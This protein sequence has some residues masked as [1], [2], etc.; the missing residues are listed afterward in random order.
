MKTPEKDV[1][2]SNKSVIS[3]DIKWN[4]LRSG[5][6]GVKSRRNEVGS[7]KDDV[8]SSKDAVK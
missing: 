8:M 1:K 2:R 7:I 4:E 5:K 3:G 6:N